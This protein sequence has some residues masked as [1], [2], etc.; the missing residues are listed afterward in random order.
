[1]ICWHR[2]GARAALGAVV[3][4]MTTALVS[5]VP[6]HAA[7]DQV[8]APGW[9][10][11]AMSVGAAHGISQGEGMTV[12]VLDTGIRTD[13]PALEGRA[14]EGPDMLGEDD[15]GAAYYGRH[16]TAMASSVLDVAPKAKVLGIRVIRDDEDPDNPEDP[17]A[18]DADPAA[19][20]ALF[21]GVRQAVEA[22]ADVISMSLGDGETAFTR[23]DVDAERAIAEANANGIVVVASA[24]NEA[25]EQNGVS[26]PAALTGVIGVGAST[27]GGARAEFSQVHN[28]V[29]VL[30]PGVGI[31]GADID[32][33][34]SPGD[35]TSPAGALVAGTAALIRSA[36]PDLTPRQ[37]E[38]A[39]EETASHYSAG[40]DPE[41][42][43]GEID[44][45]AA[46]KAAGKMTPEEVV[47]AATVY[48]GPE[49]IGPGD[50]GT[51]KVKHAALD[52]SYVGLAMI[53][54]VPGVLML[55]VG[56]ILFRT[57]GRA[58]RRATA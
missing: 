49:H 50:D 44:A 27:P 52:W 51:P 35:G 10:L 5:P 32:G 15:H 54:V 48:S 39:L 2:I 16:G 6:A 9:E 25:D 17:F 13:H 40:H 58:R 53:G 47:P 18:F 11:K 57:G 33:G 30:A 55:A 36:H 31:N 4:A 12:A 26:Y 3:A 28:Y 45:A 56:I 20:G 46:L 19:R 23:Y 38:E 34:R 1:V 22:G 8:G 7:P 24:G 37:V 43:F 42:G 14:E 21:R 41:T 29:D